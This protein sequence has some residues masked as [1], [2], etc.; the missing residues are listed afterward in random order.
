MSTGGL[1]VAC[2]K[3]AYLR[4]SGLSAATS[5]IAELEKALVRAGECDDDDDDGEEYGEVPLVLR[6]MHLQLDPIPAVSSKIIQ[7]KDAL[8]VE[9]LEGLR[10]GATTNGVSVVVHERG[11]VNGDLLRTQWRG[12]L[13]E[14]CGAWTPSRTG[15]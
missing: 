4:V 7:A 15:S 6:E 9:T 1:A 5:F 11:L 14:E 13:K 12:R 8:L 2:P 10:Q 3:L